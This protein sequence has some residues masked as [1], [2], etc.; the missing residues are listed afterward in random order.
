MPGAWDE[1]VLIY[2]LFA[3][4]AVSYFDRY[5]F[6]PFYPVS[7]F[8]PHANTHLS[9]SS[10]QRQRLV[11]RSTVYGYSDVY[12][13]CPWRRGRHWGRLGRLWSAIAIQSDVFLPPVWAP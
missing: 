8:D 1:C 3:L 11:G 13:E 7:S 10:K 5:T 2:L 4:N 6:L 9:W 12:S